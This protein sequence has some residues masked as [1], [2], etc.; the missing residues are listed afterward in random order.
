MIFLLLLVGVFP[1]SAVEATVEVG[2]AGRAVVSAVN[3][4]WL[5]VSNP[6]ALPFSGEIRISAKIGSPWRGEA[7]YTAGIP[8]FLAPFG[9]AKLLIPWP[10][11]LGTAALAVEIRAGE[12]GVFAREVPVWLETE[13]LRGALGPPGDPAE[14]SLSP[15]D[16][17]PDPLFLWPFSQ[18]RINLVLPGEALSVV[19][20]WAM[21]LGG[22]SEVSPPFGVLL[23]SLPLRQRVQGLR[24]SPPLWA[25]LVP[26]LVL[27]L[28]ALG[29]L[30]ARFSRGNI[31]LFLAFSAVFLGFSLIYGVWQEEPRAIHSVLVRVSCPGFTMFNLDLW[32]GVA[33]RK[34]RWA[35]P[36]FWVEL[37]PERGWEGLDLLWVHSAEGWRTEAWLSPGR[38]RL[39]LRLAEEALPFPALAEAAPPAWLQ[40][41]LRLPWEKARIKTALV[42]EKESQTEVF[43]VWVP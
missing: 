37:L 28:F 36:G 31:G 9:R 1:A 4:V 15:H 12:R 39:F 14:V 2:W 7:R 3:P 5:T 18:L 11:A 25:A 24:P 6:G 20:A 35:L 21:F 38:P 13:R 23:A 16:I 41:T 30:L 42:R 33:W 43:Q 22:I 34:E 19:R 10:V 29:P 27:Y 8:L 40:Q 32:G 17:P 26:G